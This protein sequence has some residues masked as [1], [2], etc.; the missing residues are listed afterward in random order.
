MSLLQSLTKFETILTAQLYLKIF[1]R[2]TPL[3]KYLQTDGMFILQAQQMVSSTLEF[4][5]KE[6]RNFEDIL[7]AGKNV[8]KWANELIENED[9]INNLIPDNLPNVRIRKKKTLM[10]PETFNNLLN[11]IEP[12]I[13]KEDTKFRLSI[14]ANERLALTLRYLATGDSFAS[15]SLLF[16]VSKSSISSIVP[17]VCTAIIE[18]LQDYTNERIRFCIYKKKKVQC[19]D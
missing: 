1:Q 9:E 18:E 13:R 5:K 8:V 2:T 10:T 17:E 14:P 19:A 3:S 16:K 7:K 12:K 4:L 15:L 6:A 11:L